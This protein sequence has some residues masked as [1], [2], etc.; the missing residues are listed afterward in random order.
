[1]SDYILNNETNNSIKIFYKERADLTHTEVLSVWELA[2]GVPLVITTSNP[3]SGQSPV[4]GTF[5]ASGQTSTSFTPIAGR[6]FNVTISGTFVTGSTQLQR[7]FD[8]GTTWFNL[9]SGGSGIML[10][11]AG[12]SEQYTESE[13]GVRY[14]LRCNAL[15]SGSI[16]YRISQ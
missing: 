4:T 10:F 16:V 9:T 2:N 14:R 3:A 13:T 11:T 7:S 15:V 5:T 1:M 12:A 6:P 8:N